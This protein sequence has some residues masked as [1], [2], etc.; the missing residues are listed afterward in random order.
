M[1]TPSPVIGLAPASLGVLYG[2]SGS[3][4]L[5]F[6]ETAGTGFSP[7]LELQ[8]TAPSDNLSFGTAS[9]AGLALTTKTY[10]FTR[11]GTSGPF[12][13]V[14]PITG[15]TLTSATPDTLLIW[16]LPVGSYVASAPEL[17]VDLP[18]T[19]KPT[20]PS[21]GPC[22]CGLAAATPWGAIHS[23]TRSRI[24]RSAPRTWRG[25]WYPHRSPSARAATLRS[26]KRSPAPT[27][28]ASGGCRPTSPMGPS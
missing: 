17:V 5:T 10:T 27:S 26:R 21:W 28:A 16:Q 4:R 18:V 9:W 12:S 6:D 23:T 1:A 14:N 19:V 24:H 25:R 2:D 20:T 7:W 8:V 13:L 11:T 3:L 15:V 22:R